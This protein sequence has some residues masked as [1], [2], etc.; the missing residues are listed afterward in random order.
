MAQ[1]AFVT[2]LPLPKM[3]SID[4][5]QKNLP[6]NRREMSL[7]H[8]VSSNLRFARRNDEANQAESSLTL[9]V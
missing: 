8:F 1:K 2:F 5:T 3:V 9:H 7:T 6:E 4:K